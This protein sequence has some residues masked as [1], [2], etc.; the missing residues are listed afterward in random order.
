MIP[1]SIY[2]SLPVIYI[3]CGLA[4]LFNL[5][6][7]LGTMSGLILV[8]LSMMVSVMRYNNRRAT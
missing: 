3:L 8:T 5:D 7:A 4:V 1:N 6:H 2:E